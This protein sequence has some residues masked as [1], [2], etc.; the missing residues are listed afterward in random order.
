MIDFVSFLFIHSAN[1]HLFWHPMA[2]HVRAMQAFVVAKKIDEVRRAQTEFPDPFL[3]CGDLNSD[4]LS[5]A[6]QLLTSKSIKSDHHDCWNYLHT[7]QMDIDDNDVEAMVDS[8]TTAEERRSCHQNQQTEISSSDTP[9]PT[10]SL[11]NSFPSLLS[12]CQPK[13]PFTNF[14][15]KFVETLDYVLASQ[16]AADERA[17]FS[18]KRSAAMPTI[19]DVEE[20]VSMVCIPWFL[21][22]PLFLF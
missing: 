5:G 10:I 12:G 13:P 15:P 14:T 22:R 7:Y 20:F 9:P 17:G 19:K 21:Q 8:G 4:P 1:T 3:L 16:L 11:P 2:D 6:S 18:H